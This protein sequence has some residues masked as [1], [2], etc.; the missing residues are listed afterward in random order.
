MCFAM[1]KT[2]DKEMMKIHLTSQDRTHSPYRRTHFASS[3]R[4][5]RTSS[6]RNQPVVEGALQQ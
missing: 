4:H 6:S 3:R 2:F 5:P 1:S